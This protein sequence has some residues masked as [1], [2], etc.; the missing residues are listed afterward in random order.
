MGGDDDNSVQFIH[1]DY[2]N[3]L[4]I[5]PESFDTLVSLYAGFVSEHCT[6]YLRVGG[7]LLVGPSHGDAAMA[8][9]DPRYQL[10]GVVMSRSGSYGV[11]TD[12][13]D[14]YLIPKEP[15]EVTPTLLHEK[16]LGI[17]YTRSPFA[18]LFARVETDRP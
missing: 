6:Q 9:I 5:E 18:Y 12:R 8:S 10:S 15:I 17:S 1:A 13:L 14:S 16:G 7:T 2:R 3:D 4:E 11:S